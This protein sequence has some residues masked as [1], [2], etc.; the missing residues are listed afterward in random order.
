MSIKFALTAH[1]PS[2]D[3]MAV[4][5]VCIFFSAAHQRQ[6]GQLERC[7]DSSANLHTAATSS[8][9]GNHSSV[10]N[11]KPKCTWAT[12]RENAARFCGVK[13]GAAV[14]APFIPAD[15]G[16]D[17]VYDININPGRRQTLRAL[18]AQTEVVVIF[19]RRLG[20]TF[21]PRPVRH[22]GSDSELWTQS[23]EIQTI[24]Q[25]HKPTLRCNLARASRKL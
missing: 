20:Q 18:E 21:R 13:I 1:D 11:S 3:S 7:S 6:P 23:A 4:K 17:F 8:I 9:G 5:S 16:F 2:S 25:R 10:I 12:Y 24:T 14:A 19:L 22:G 15:N